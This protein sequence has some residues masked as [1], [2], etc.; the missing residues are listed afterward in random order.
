M[1]EASLRLERTGF[2]LDVDIAAPRAGISALFGPSGCGKTTVLRAIAGLV[3]ARG[4]VALGDEAWQDDA[5]GIF[6]P[7]HRRSI[8]YVV[9]EAALFPHMSVRRNLE[10]GL[11][12]AEGQRRRSVDLDGLVELL[13]IA[14]L[15]ERSP[16]SLSGGER[17]RVA[18]A[19]ALA[20]APRLL[21]MDEPLAALDA[22]RK[23]EILPYLERL[24]DELETP[25]LY[26]SHS[27][28]EVARL[29]DRVVLMREGRIEAEGP[30]TEVLSRADLPMGASGDAGVVI[31]ARVVEHDAPYQLSRIRFPGGALWVGGLDAPVGRR[32]RVRIIARDVSVALE[33]P[34]RTSVVNVLPATIEGIREEGATMLLGLRIDPATPDDTGPA[35]QDAARLLARIT[36]RSFDT[37]GLAVGERVHAQVKA[38]ALMRGTGG[39]R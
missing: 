30:I 2:A 19:R 25:V 16:A 13:G 3:R 39:E 11:R 21:L 22:Q 23:S 32:V 12:R 9:Q 17:Q 38:V 31:D 4:R 27:I 36:R 28:D 10:Y 26:V 20:P 29:A 33:R 18:I 15:L 24:H 5:R 35:A 37:L 1:I 7:T 8:G 6:V 14:H 34:R